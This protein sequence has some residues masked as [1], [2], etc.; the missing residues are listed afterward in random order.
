MLVSRVRDRL[1][2]FALVVVHDAL[3]LLAGLPRRLRLPR[4]TQDPRHA[5]NR[6]AGTGRVACLLLLGRHRAISACE[7]QMGP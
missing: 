3:N 5:D 1:V 2:L 6:G 4:R 7:G